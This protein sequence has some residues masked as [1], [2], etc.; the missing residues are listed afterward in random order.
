MTTAPPL[1]RPVGALL[2]SVV[3]LMLGNGPLTTLISLRLNAAGASPTLTGLVATAYFLGLTL[4][5]LQAFRVILRV[6]HIRAFAVF[7]S[8]VSATGLVYALWQNAAL[9][10]LVRLVDGFCMAG[11]FICIESWL[12]DRAE[13]ARRGA[14]LAA[15]MVCVYGAQAAGQGLLNI[16][17]AGDLR[18]FLLLSILMGLSVLPISMTSKSPTALPDVA[19][20][21][22]RQLYRISPL[23]MVGTVTSGLLLGAVYALAPLFARGS[24]LDLAGTTLFMTALILGGMALQWPLGRLSDRFDRRLV[25]L[26]TLAA[27][28]ASSILVLLAAPHG[29][30]WLLTTGALFGGL[31]FALYPLCVSHTNDWLGAGDRVAASGGLVLAYS[32]GAA[33]GPVLASTGMSLVGRSGLFLYAGLV[34]LACLGFGLWRLTARATLPAEQQHPYQ[35]LPGT[36]PAAAPLHPMAEGENEAEKEATGAG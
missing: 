14:L 21:S 6:G 29:T 15:Y 10:A 7:A 5:A 2:L 28:T 26:G 8:T 35:G 30:A 17:G 22:L 34:S 25:I 36:T 23:G 16:G 11:L 18:P 24:G 32:F 33:A 13:P 9:W 12:N 19:S 20:L 3:L 1:L 4:G 31:V 27:L